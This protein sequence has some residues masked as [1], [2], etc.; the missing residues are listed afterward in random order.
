MHLLILFTAMVGMKLPMQRIKGPIEMLVYIFLEYMTLYIVRYQYYTFILFPQYRLIYTMQYDN[1]KYRIH[2]ESIKK[3][4][5]KILLGKNCDNFRS[6]KQTDDLQSVYVC[7]CVCVCKKAGGD[8]YT[9]S[10][11]QGIILYSRKI[12]QALRIGSQQVL[13]KFKFGDLNSQC[14]RRACINLH[15]R[16]FNLAIFTK[17]T[18]SPN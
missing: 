11:T 4:K 10:S 5:R 18:K 17:F 8:Q 7:M 1:C 15:W 2:F 16:V 14:H 6:N 12:W 9:E 3:V 13:V